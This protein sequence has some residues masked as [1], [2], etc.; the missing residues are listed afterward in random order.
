MAWCVDDP[1]VTQSLPHLLLPLPPSLQVKVMQLVYLISC[2]AV[3]G[4]TGEPPTIG[5]LAEQS[6]TRYLASSGMTS[7]IELCTSDG[8]LF[9]S[10]DPVSHVLSDNEVVHAQV[11]TSSMEPVQQRY[12]NVCAANDTGESSDTSC[13]CC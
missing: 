6:A 1:A 3:L 2:P 13:T 4:N 12:A 8:A 5:W 9:D 7:K 11:M 10:S